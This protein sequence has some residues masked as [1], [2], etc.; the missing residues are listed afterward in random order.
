ME[1]QPKVGIGVF[2]FNNG[3]IVLQKRKGAHGSGEWSLPG[4]HLEFGES[5]EQAAER[6]VLE[7]TGLKIKN[8]KFVGVTNDIFKKEN[9]HYITIF[10][11]GETD[12]ANLLVKEKDRIEEIGWFDPKNLPEPLFLPVKNLMKDSKLE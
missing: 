2:V 7:E 6:E 9:L 3:K 8:V 10:M 5:W 1:T 11:R 12:G 4:G